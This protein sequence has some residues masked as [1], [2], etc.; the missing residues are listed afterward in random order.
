MS[1]DDNKTPDLTLLYV[2]FLLGAL[3]IALV[4]I[5]GDFQTRITNLEQQAQASKAK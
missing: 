4:S 3:V 5:L 2:G 1:G